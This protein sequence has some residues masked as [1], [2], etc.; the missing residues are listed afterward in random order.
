MTPETVP[1]FRRNLEVEI[2]ERIR[3]R[4]TALERAGRNR[5]TRF[6]CQ[7]SVGFDRCWSWSS[8]VRHKPSS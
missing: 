2:N 6:G 5:A 8:F 4:L 3:R 7:Q 1:E